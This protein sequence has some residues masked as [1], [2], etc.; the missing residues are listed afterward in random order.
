MPKALP[1]LRTLIVGGEVNRRDV[2]DTWATTVNLITGYGPTETC[3][4][5]TAHPVHE[6]SKPSNIGRP[7]GCATWIVDQ[8]DHS[9]LVPDG[10]IGELLIQGPGVARGYLNDKEK[11]DEVFVADPD[12]IPEA[13]RGQYMFYKS[14]DLCR[15]APDGNIE[16]LRRKDFQ[17]KYHGNRVE[18]GEIEYQLQNGMRSLLSCCVEI[19]EPEAR[20]KR[21]AIVAF[22]Q[23]P[24]DED[25]DNYESLNELAVDMTDKL[26]EQL[27]DLR[28]YVQKMLPAYMVPSLYVPMSKLP[29]NVSQK[30]ERKVIQR[31]LEKQPS[32]LLE[33]WS[34]GSGKV[35]TMPTEDKD[36][37]MQA[38]WV[39]VLGAMPEDVGVDDNFFAVGGDSIGKK[40]CF[41][42]PHL[43][44]HI[45][46]EVSRSQPRRICTNQSR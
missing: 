34:L 26:R 41:P 12:F 23:V 20:Q 15:K 29:Q 39:E 17:V 1:T 13:S 16:F 24:S 36:V 35:K 2:I 28:T 33:L 9:I 8:D 27:L 3:V 4:F 32:D 19:A 45:A 22:L 42:N 10:T 6:L 7:I 44:T 5:C 11:T 37:R 38:L 30:M 40:N 21:Q 18:L 25:K 46:L 43:T 14:G 31:W